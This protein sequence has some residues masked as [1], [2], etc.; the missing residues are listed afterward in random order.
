MFS[1]I[2]TYL[3]GDDAIE[4]QLT[5]DAVCQTEDTVNDWIFVDHVSFQGKTVKISFFQIIIVIVL[6]VYCVN[7]L[8]NR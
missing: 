2:S 8:L 5:D 1:A 3:F 6:C 7:A 4:V